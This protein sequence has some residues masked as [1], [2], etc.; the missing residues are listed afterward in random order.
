MSSSLIP[1]LTDDSSSADSFTIAFTCSLCA[2]TFFRD[3]LGPGFAADP[4]FESFFIFF[5]YLRLLKAVPLSI[6]I[7]TP[8]RYVL[9]R[10]EM[11]YIPIHLDICLLNRV[12][13]RCKRTCLIELVAACSRSVTLRELA[14]FTRGPGASL[15][16]L[17]RM[18]P[19]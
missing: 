17:S 8:F 3:L 15:L 6:V 10:S 19:S 2:S 9:C 16:G 13:S 7:Y 12:H 11:K 14:G 1:S 5:V 4:A 18:V